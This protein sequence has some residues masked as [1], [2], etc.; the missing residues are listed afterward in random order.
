M[1]GKRI[2]A[3]SIR[4]FLSELKKEIRIERA[5]LFG[6]YARGKA[7]RYS[8]VDIAIISADFQM[9]S[10]IERLVLLGKVAWKVGATEI[11]AL[12]FTPEEYKR[13]NRFDF[14]YEIKR[15]GKVVFNK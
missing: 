9:L 11:E 14:L 7:K 10:P 3:L 4:R 2:A 8:D 6:S 1:A 15:K 5:I 13:T 12:G